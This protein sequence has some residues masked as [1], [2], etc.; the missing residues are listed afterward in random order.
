MKQSSILNEVLGPIMT[1]PSSSHTAAQG[2][3][4]RAVRN[5][6]G[7]PIASAAVVYDCHGSYPNTHEGQGCDFGFTAGLLGLDMDDPRFRDSIELARRQSVEIEFRVESLKGEHPNE[8][9]VD[10]RTEPGGPVGLSV[11]SQSTGG[12]TFLLTELNGFPISYDGQR[13]KAFL[14]CA[15]G[16]EKAVAHA[17]TEAGGQFV[18]R[19]PAERPV[20]AAAMP[21][22]ASALFEVELISLAGQK[23]PEEAKKRSLSLYCCAPLVSVP[24]RLRP[25]RG[26]FTAEG[27]L[28]YAAEHQ[29]VS[30][31]ELAVVYETRLGSADRTDLE[32]EMLHVLRAMERSM[33]PPPAD[34]PV[35][36]YLVPRQA[37]ELDDKMPLDMGVLNGCMR[38]AMAVMENGCA[39]RVVV[40]APTAG[41]S[42][43]IPA[44]VVGVGRTLGRT[45][46][47]ILDALWAAGL[48]GA[49]I[50]N[51]ATFGAEV[52][53]CQAEIGAAS[54]M[55]AAGVVQLLGGTVEEGF[56]AAALAMQSLLGLICDPV[57]GLVEF[58]CIQRNVTASVMAA[59]AAN[60]AMK[61]VRS[62]I[63]LD[64]TIK[65]MLDVGRGLP[66]SLR[67]TCEGGLC[68]T[69]TGRQLALQAV[70]CKARK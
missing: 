46:G 24:L 69:P 42:G 70:K 21:Q 17:L 8:A 60:M 7:R 63:P 57:A 53:G 37:A 52:A 61:G 66:A 62:P 23:L 31:A 1:G 28:K 55:A 49:F 34:D 43:V 45:E 44:S 36:N 56:H 30:M 4:G 18:L 67:C 41:S 22:G 20:T 32:Q 5:L 54:C 29:T 51:Q 33:T 50:A 6:W 64:E 16:E 14:I 68:A 11:L 26:F 38:N 12:G 47:E 48:V 58:P 13:E 2:K 9:R 40:A 59:A 15:A 65:A 19:H 39:H 27:A 25:E 35:P 10:I 3:I